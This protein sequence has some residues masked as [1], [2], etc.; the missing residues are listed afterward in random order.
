MLPTTRRGGLASPFDTHKN[1]GPP[2]TSIIEAKHAL[3]SGSL[4]GAFVWRPRHCSATVMY[5]LLPEAHFLTSKVC[6]SRQAASTP[7]LVCV[8]RSVLGHRAGVL[9]ASPD[10]IAQMY[11]PTTVFGTLAT[12][13]T[14]FTLKCGKKC[15]ALNSKEFTPK[16]GCTSGRVNDP[17]RLLSTFGRRF[18][19]RCPVWFRRMSLRQETLWGRTRTATSS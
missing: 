7:T 2:Y 13:F 8:P 4:S 10:R 19:F 12:C 18:I 3:V 14:P 16:R 6:G 17:P 5:T 1:R 15:R 9:L 11:T